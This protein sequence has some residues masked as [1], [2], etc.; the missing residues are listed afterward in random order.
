MVPSLP[1]SSPTPSRP[2]TP[3]E[4]DAPWGD[5]D[6]LQALDA[7]VDEFRVWNATRTDAEILANYRLTRNAPAL[8]ADQSLLNLYYDFT[9][10]AD[11][12]SLVPDGSALSN[13][14]AAGSLPTL[15]N[16]MTYSTS[17]PKQAPT[18][19]RFLPSQAPVFGDA[20]VV[21]VGQGRTARVALRATDADA[22]DD[23]TFTI[24][25][26]P[27]DGVLTHPATGVALS[28]ADTLPSLPRDGALQSALVDYSAPSGAPLPGDGSPVRP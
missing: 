28:V 21:A 6:E 15:R 7:I 25:S 5:F 13:D 27:S 18:K 23:L 17:R 11:H 16:E 20:V 2:P 12:P 14:G 22:N 24:A 4:P 9:T 1:D 19:P 3:Q 26:L 8:Q 10:A